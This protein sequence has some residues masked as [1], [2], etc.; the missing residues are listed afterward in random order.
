MRPAGRRR[1]SPRLSREVP[2]MD[3]SGQPSLTPAESQ[4]R[5]F[6]LLR[7]VAYRYSTHFQPL[8]LDAIDSIVSQALAT[9]RRADH[10]T[11]EGIYELI[12]QLTGAYSVTRGA[13]R[14][15]VTRLRTASVLETVQSDGQTAYQMSTEEFSKI[16]AERVMS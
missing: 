5:Q 14:D 13:I 12:E 9:V 16:D 8:R 3:R 6:R 2:Q 11:I 10:L 7:A 1:T 4:L 15:S